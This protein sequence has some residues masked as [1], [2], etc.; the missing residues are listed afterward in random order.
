[1]G[2]L[3]LAQIQ[4]GGNAPKVDQLVFLETVIL[5]RCVL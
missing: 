2:P 5:E 1:M 3:Q 4:R